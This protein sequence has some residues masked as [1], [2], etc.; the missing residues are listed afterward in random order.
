MLL[1][2]INRIVYL[3]ELNCNV[4]I[5]LSVCKRT[6][7]CAIIKYMWFDNDCKHWWNASYIVILLSVCEVWSCSLQTSTER[8]QSNAFVIVNR[9]ECQLGDELVFSMF[10]SMLWIYKWLPPWWWNDMCSSFDI[11]RYVNFFYYLSV[12]CPRQWRYYSLVI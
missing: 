12:T 9:L 2:I 10:L 7:L 11:F 6:I 4:S 8:L 1:Y 5:F 3:D